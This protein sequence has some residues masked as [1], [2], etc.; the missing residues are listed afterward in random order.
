MVANA[1]E[2]TNLTRRFGERT[3]VEDLTLAI[4]A[5]AQSG[6]KL[7]LRGRGLP[8]EPAGDQYVRLKIVNPP[9]DSEAARTLF[10]RLQDELPFDPRAGL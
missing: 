1:I 7:R 5:G 10:R 6:Q 2:T 3:A 9:A 8:G 4:P